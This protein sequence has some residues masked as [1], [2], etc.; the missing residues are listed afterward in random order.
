MRAGEVGSIVPPFTSLR[1][2]GDFF[3]E[4]NRQSVYL[5]DIDHR[6]D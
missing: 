5:S 3:E 1:L 4:F 2:P 6:V